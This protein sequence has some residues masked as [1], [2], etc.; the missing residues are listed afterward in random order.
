MTAEGN[1]GPI[2]KS[3]SNRVRAPASWDQ[4]DPT[5][6][7]DPVEPVAVDLLFVEAREHEADVVFVVRLWTAFAAMAGHSGQGCSRQ[8]CSVSWLGSSGKPIAG[9]SAATACQKWRSNSASGQIAATRRT[10]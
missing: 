1:P 6:R 5:G 10:Q 9:T 7:D 8:C 4:P 2:P 3:S